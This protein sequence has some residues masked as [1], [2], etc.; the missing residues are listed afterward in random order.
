MVLGRVYKIT[1]PG[2]EQC[3]V[4][5]TC[6]TLKERLR[7]HRKDMGR[8][9]A[10]KRRYVTS[11]QILAHEGA[12]IEQLEE[13][14]F[15]DNSILHQREAYWLEELSAVNKYK[16]S[17]LSKREYMRQYN[18]NH[19]WRGEAKERHRQRHAEKVTCPTC[20]KIMRRDTLKRHTRLKH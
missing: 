20:G 19:P 14:T 9:L 13:V 18:Q 7:E 6:Q 3:Y 15:E 1:A 10:G 16:P 17:G 8:W 5:S 4:G 2:H 12:T 11:F